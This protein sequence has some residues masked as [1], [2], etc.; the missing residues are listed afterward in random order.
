M[1]IYTYYENINFKLQDELLDLWKLSWTRHGFDPIILSRDDAK[2]SSLYNEYYDFVQEIHNI[3]IGQYLPEYSYHLAAQLEIVAFNTIETPSY[4][5]DYD[6]INNGFETGEKLE[7]IV[8][9]RNADC[10]CFASGDKNGWKRYIEF[11][12]NQKHN[13]I[14]WCKNEYQNTKRKHFH[15]QDFLVAVKQ[16]GI[17]S[18]IYK[19]YRN[20]NIAGADYDPEGKNTCKIIH[21]S[22]N[23]MSKIKENNSNYRDSNPD[24]MRILF[25]KE[26]LNNTNKSL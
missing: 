6:M 9:W 26:I 3:S 23:N 24:L 25:A 18:N 22:H 4:V 10:S 20:I 21:L 15:D 12:F 8:H 5:S 17:H 13:I 14:E 2:K 7:S 1:K 11:L 19:M 16:T